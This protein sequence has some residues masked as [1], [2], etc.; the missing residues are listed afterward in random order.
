MRFACFLSCLVVAASI[1][2]TGSAQDTAPPEN[3]VNSKSALKQQSVTE[4]AFLSSD[5]SFRYQ[6]PF[7]IPSFR[8]LE[9]KLGLSYTSGDNTNGRAENIVGVGWTLL[10]MSSIERTAT[11]GGAPTYE[12]ERDIYSLDG[13]EL[14][15]CENTSGGATFPSPYALGYP[16]SRIATRE[17]ASC[18]TGDSSNAGNL[19][20][21]VDKYLRIRARTTQINGASVNDFEVTD[22]NGTVYIYRA[23]GVLAGITPN[24][25]SPDFETLFART[26][27]LAEVHD[28][29]V[30]QNTVTYTYS[31]DTAA[32]GYAYRP[33]Q[34]AY[35]GYLIDFN[36]AASP[37]SSWGLGEGHNSIAKQGYRLE[38]VIVRDGST[39]I[40]GYNLIHDVAPFLGRAR[41]TGLGIYG[42]NLALTGPVITS[43]TQLP[44]YSFTYAPDAV[45]FDI[46]DYQSNPAIKFHTS[47]TVA[48]LNGDQRDEA[49][50][51]NYTYIYRYVTNAIRYTWSLPRT[52]YSFDSGRALSDQSA[53]AQAGFFPSASFDTKAESRIAT[54]K[55][56]VGVIRY[57]SRLVDGVFV[58]N[59]NHM[60][61]H[62]R[63]GGSGNFSSNIL[64][65]VNMAD[66]VVTSSYSFQ[67]SDVPQDC[68]KSSFQPLIGNFDDDDPSQEVIYGAMVFDVVAGA[69]TAKS[70]WVGDLVTY[71][72]TIEVPNQGVPNSSRL[73]FASHWVVDLD[74]DG[75]DEIVTPAAFYRRELWSDGSTKFRRYAF[76]NSPL[77][78][79]SGNG[80]DDETAWG[81]VNGDGLADLIIHERV[82]ANSGSALK[83]ALGTGRDF[84]SAADWGVGQAIPGGKISDTSPQPR[85]LAGDINGDGLT[86]V[87]LH[88][89]FD[90]DSPTVE[91]KSLLGWVF[92]SSGTGF[93]RLYKPDGSDFN[94]E[95]PIGMGDF[96][97][98]GFLDILSGSGSTTSS[99]ATPKVYFF[100]SPQPNVLNKIVTPNGGEIVPAY[101]PNSMFA[102]N[103]LPRV[104]RVVLSVTEK[105]GRGNERTSTYAYEGG[106]FDYDH[107]RSMGY[108]KVTTTLPKIGAETENPRLITKYYQTMAL[109]GSVHYR[110]LFSGPEANPITQSYEEVTIADTNRNEGY[111][112]SSAPVSSLSGENYGGTMVYRLKAVTETAFGELASE[113]DYGLVGSDGSN[114]NVSDD[115]VTLTSYVPN[116][117]K[118]IVN[119]PSSVIVQTGSG[120]V[121]DRSRRLR[122]QYFRY[123]GAGAHTTQPSIGNLTYMAQWTGDPASNTTRRIFTRS[124]DDWGNLTLESDAKSNNTASTYDTTRHLFRLS[125]TNAASQVESATWDDACQ[126]PATS[127]DING[128]VTTF[129]YDVFCRET[130]QLFATGQYLQT[131]YNNFG[132]PSTQYVKRQSKS[133]SSVTGSTLH[134]EWTY[135]DGMGQTYKT[136]TSGN[137][138]S[139][140]D[141]VSTVSAYDARGNLAWTSIPLPGLNASTSPAQR[142]SYDYDALNR[143]TSVIAA[144]GTKTTIGYLVERF[145]AYGTTPLYYPGTQTLDAHC[146]DLATDNSVCGDYREFFD[147]AGRKIRDLRVDFDQTDVTT[148]TLQGRRT[149]Y[150]YDLLGQLISVSDPSGV[151]W[152]YTYDAFGDRLTANDPGL[153]LWS[154]SYDS[155]HNLTL[156]T[157]AKSQLISFTYDGLNRVTKKTVKASAAATARTETDYVYDEARAGYYNA[158]KQTSQDV[159]RYDSAGASTSVHSVER[160][161]HKNGK[162][163]LERHAIDGLTYTLQTSFTGADT[164][165]DQ[166]LPYIPGST[167]RSWVGPF[168]YDAAG[169]IA[170]MTNFIPAITYNI[171]GNPTRVD[172]AN[173][174]NDRM[175]YDADRGWL[176][177]I[178]GFDSAGNKFYRAAF[179]RT[180]T[181]RIANQTTGFTWAGVTSDWAGSYDYTYDYAGRLLSA[182]HSGTGSSPDNQY[183]TY[184]PAGRMLSKGSTSPDPISGPP[185]SEAYTYGG[186]GT[187][188]VII[189]KH[190]PRKVG[191]T[192]FTYDANG[193]MLT[194]LGGRVMTYDAENRP[195]SVTFAGK[196]T[197]YVY[198]A[199]G[200]RLKKIENLAT[201]QDCATVPATTPATVYFG[202]VEIRNFKIAGQEQ[203]ITYP[204]P[205]VR[206]T[207]GKL[208]ANA[209]YLHLDHL[210]S[211]RAVTDA[212]GLKVEGAVYKPFGEQNEWLTPGLAV[213][214]TKGFI[215]ERFDADAG[216]QYLNARYYDPILG[217]FLQPDWL[218]VMQQGVGTNRFSY[219]FND[220]VNRNDTDGKSWLDR[221][222]DNVFGGGSF[223]RTFG[224]KGSAISDKAFGND[225]ERAYAKNYFD[226]GSAYQ[227]NHIDYNGS[228]ALVDD[229]GSDPDAD[230][231]IAIEVGAVAIAGPAIGV[232]GRVVLY[233]GTG[234]RVF[235]AGGTRAADAATEIA[236]NTG[237][238]T[239]GM[240]NA[241]KLAVGAENILTKLGMKWQG[242]TRL[243]SVKTVWEIAS[244]GFA[245]SA[246]GETAIAVIGP[247][248]NE[249]S[250]FYA[251]EFPILAQKGI[252]VIYEFLR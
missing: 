251:R 252:G 118:Y 238:K 147:H 170:G 193:N 7:D 183:L 78:A 70:T 71:C 165:A 203:V 104:Q 39:A 111:P 40:R 97:G 5:G 154:M 169:R 51:F 43:G 204:H 19:S 95:S 36:Y 112:Y 250:I 221:T 124:Y 14:V 189:P 127:T 26:Y 28:Q 99:P 23:A 236:V 98:D 167:N 50:F 232:G 41:L 240:T 12:N 150:R 89:G 77:I 81:D 119:H 113:I 158:G 225:H 130:K 88:R 241:G 73:I 132:N 74:G 27:L 55:D 72:E 57:F 13:V 96:D 53:S 87:M 216:L 102:D 122:S 11:G 175:T 222:W 49:I 106:R 66:G 151:T 21:I 38:S 153:G 44:G 206:L 214:E 177:D 140:S 131:T 29:Q 32:N 155:N 174:A 6:V 197:C 54:V 164:V 31:F 246:T 172:Y 30:G 213:Q 75:I 144:D 234:A 185:A 218:E 176:D 101:G 17:N 25:S 199:D 178:N 59:A 187:N 109:V 208:P 116:T 233:G 188:G 166:N 196:R 34:I 143:P 80:K 171:W 24:S 210:G 4:P 18:S 45:A 108:R 180:A 3:S 100:N 126:K 212:S 211:V 209:S 205:N 2:G 235:W 136:A 184:D 148:D 152:A 159:T 145:S 9:P 173:G 69:L 190:A 243:T 202:P 58:P 228:K 61:V 20:A 82:D 35:G 76:T 223:N 248:A 146:Y 83:V 64:Q 129:T 194:G 242:S 90:G 244:V 186:T 160:D 191:S 133:G 182:V 161:Y 215:G 56:N 217:L 86:D 163:Q 157:D 239:L 123:D 114:L 103:L 198:G 16:D 156:Q 179:T 68:R 139:D 137:T 168:V 207:N 138:S 237:A 142:I 224:D 37:M 8:G 1:A 79:L 84:L 117:A 15:A 149:N 201:T 226:N 195:L 245:R 192:A 120:L 33:L 162:A 91:Q 220:P 10:G 65:T 93:K 115:S 110:E 52:Y 42:K 92:L 22:K 67:A 60:L 107:R 47:N 181:G 200:G 121:D 231:K 105:D 227:E 230:M 62:T 46:K 247:A 134:Y 249:G 135:F 219:S 48:D 85:M 141:A 128:V 125:T 94:I 63:I 229:V